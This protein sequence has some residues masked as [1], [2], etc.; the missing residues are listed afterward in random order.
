M[1]EIQAAMWAIQQGIRAGQTFNQRVIKLFSGMSNMD[2]IRILLVVFKVA[3][4]KIGQENFEFL[5]F[6]MNLSWNKSKDAL[7]PNLFYYQTYFII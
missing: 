4:P 1:V 5:M 3:L 7:Y 6:Y 2:T